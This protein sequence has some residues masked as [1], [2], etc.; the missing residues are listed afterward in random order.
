MEGINQMSKFTFIDLIFY[1][2]NALTIYTLVIF[3][4][5]P[6]EKAFLIPF[7]IFILIQVLIGFTSSLKNKDKLNNKRN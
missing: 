5:F 1:I 2:A 6:E 3:S 7:G 4:F